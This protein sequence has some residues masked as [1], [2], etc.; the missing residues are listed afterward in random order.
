MKVINNIVKQKQPSQQTTVVTMVA[1][2]YSIYEKLFHWDCPNLLTVNSKAQAHAHLS[3]R[4]QVRADC[5]SLGQD[6]IL[7]FKKLSIMCNCQMWRC[8]VFQAAKKQQTG[9][10]KWAK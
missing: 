5:I 8:L 3:N 1:A 9:M 2:Q 10:T 4:D 6:Q 7:V